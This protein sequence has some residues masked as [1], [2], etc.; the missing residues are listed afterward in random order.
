LSTSGKWNL[1]ASSTP[2]VGGAANQR[3][4]P[5]TDP[6]LPATPAAPERS[7]DN[8]ALPRH[9]ILMR[10]RLPSVDYGRVKDWARGSNPPMTQG[11]EAPR[12]RT[13]PLRIM[14][15]QQAFRSMASPIYQ[16]KL[17]RNLVTPLQS[18]F[19]PEPQQ[20]KETPSAQTDTSTSSECP[21]P[22]PEKPPRPQ[23]PS[24]VYRQSPP[25]Q[26]LELPMKRP[27]APVMT[28]VHPES[29]RM[30]RSI[31]E[32]TRSEDVSSYRS[33]PIRREE[34][35]RMTEHRDRDEDALESRSR[36]MVRL[37]S[38]VV[39]YAS[40]RSPPRI[41]SRYEVIG[42]VPASSEEERDPQGRR[43]QFAWQ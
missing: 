42:S 11:S 4:P 16:N 18:K 24:S 2:M 9:G 41:S 35:V 17:V 1:N 26:E 33:F 13:D 12:Q 28:T 40:P 8:A 36:P 31:L 34:Y 22:P 6:V 3:G 15:A 39:Q 7:T 23:Q 38:G 29:S 25:H 10:L 30:S 37:P 27:V 20:R 32:L 5:R 14:W 19:R 21:A 43:V